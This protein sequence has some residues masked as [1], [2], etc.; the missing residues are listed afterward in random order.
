MS[1]TAV[2]NPI[3]RLTRAI[4]VAMDEAI[5]QD[6]TLVYPSNDNKSFFTT[7]CHEELAK[8]SGCGAV[9]TIPVTRDDTL[10][11]AATFE[12]EGEPDWGPSTIK[13]CETVISLIGPIL[14]EKHLHDRGNQDAGNQRHRAVG[15]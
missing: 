5:G 4:G 13:L 8:M 10:V 15:Y 3:M 7:R 14:Y 6:T 1:G 12:H 9:C 11:G 2:L